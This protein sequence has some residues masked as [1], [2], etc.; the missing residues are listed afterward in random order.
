MRVF[1]ALTVGVTCLGAIATPTPAK[2]W[3]DHW[4]RW[5]PNA[6]RRYPPPRFYGGYRPPPYYYRPPVYLPPPAYVVPP[7]YYRPPPPVFY[8]PY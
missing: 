6:Y 1:L 5:H 7:P 8:A 4:G 2:A 3:Y